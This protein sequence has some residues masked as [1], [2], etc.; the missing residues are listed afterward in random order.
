MPDDET[1]FEWV[2]KASNLH[3]DT[4]DMD[5]IRFGEFKYIVRCAVHYAQNQQSLSTFRTIVPT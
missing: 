4:Q 3:P 1:I 5:A 2:K